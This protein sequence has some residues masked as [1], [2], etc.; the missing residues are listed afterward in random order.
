M[1]LKKNKLQNDKLR[2][3]SAGCSLADKVRLKLLSSQSLRKQ[4]A[5]KLDVLTEPNKV[6]IGVQVKIGPSTGL[7][8]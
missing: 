5:P 2:G 6:N 4:C 1:R 3:D 8:V 7:T